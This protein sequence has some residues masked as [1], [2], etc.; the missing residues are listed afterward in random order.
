[1]HST[2]VGFAIVYHLIDL[3]ITSGDSNEQYSTIWVNLIAPHMFI[4]IKVTS[5]WRN[6]SLIVSLKITENFLQSKN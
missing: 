3:S 4:V 2:N 1:M 6:L 5:I